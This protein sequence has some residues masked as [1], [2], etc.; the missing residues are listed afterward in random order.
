MWFFDDFRSK[1]KR[2]EAEN[3]LDMG[4]KSQ[5]PEKKLDYFTRYLEIIPNDVNAWTKKGRILEDMGRFDEAK[6]SYERATLLDPSLDIRVHKYSPAEGDYL[7]GESEGKTESSQ[8]Q[9]EEET[10]YSKEV[11]EK[12]RDE[13]TEWGKKGNALVDLGRHEE[14]IKC[15]EEALEL[16]PKKDEAWYNKG[17]ALAT[18]GR[19]EEAIKCYEE[20]LELN[21][22][23]DEAWY[24]KGNAL[25]TLGRKEEAIKCYEEALEIN[26]KD[27]QVWYNKGNALDDLGR[28]EEAIKCYDKA[29][30]INP[31]KD[32]A[33]Y[34]KGNALDDLGR[35]EE[36]IK[37]YDKALE[38]NP[39]DDSAWYGKGYVLDDLG[40][41]E[42][43]IKCYDKALEINPKYDAVWNNK[44]NALY[45]L[46]RKEEAIKC[47]DKAL[48]I[49]PKYDAAWYNKGNALATLGRKE[50]AI[51]C[52]DKALEINPK[53]D[54]AWYN[55]GN[56]L[57]DLGRKEEAIKCYDKAL[58]INPK[59]DE[60]WNNKGN[61]LATLGRKE[62]AIKCY[63]KALEIN[64]KKDEAWYNK[65]NALDDLGRKEE[66]IKCY[67]EALE[68]NPKKDEAWYNKG[69]ALDDLG[70]K[71]E[72]IKCYEEALELNPKKDEAWYNK[73]K[74]LSALGRKEEAI[75]CYEEALEL[76]PKKDEA[77][78]N[79][80][81]ALATL[82]RMEEA[83]KCYDKS[84][85][86][87][88][89][90]DAVWNNKGN[91]LYDLGRKEE[92]IKCYDKA[93]EINPKY[94][95]AW[96]N[97][98]IVLS[99]LG[100]KEE[101]I[102][103]YDKAL[104]INPKDDSAWYG[105]GYVLDD[106]GRKEEAIKCYD[107]SLEINPEK[108]E[109][110]KKKEALLLEINNRI[111]DKAIIVLNDAENAFEKVKDGGF[112]FSDEKLEAAWKCFEAAN[113]VEAMDLANQFKSLLLRQQ[114]KEVSENIKESEELLSKSQSL[115]IS[116]NKE[117]L[118]KA[119]IFYGDENYIE[120]MSSA[121]VFKNQ[122]MNELKQKADK[123]LIDSEEA[124]AEAKASKI[125]IEGNTLTEANKFFN[126]QSYIESIEACNKFNG[127]LTS[128]IDKRR[129]AA[130]KEI[131]EAEGFH[132]KFEALKAE[133]DDSLLKKAKACFN[134]MLYVE[135]IE[136]S[137]SFTVMAEELLPKLKPSMSVE[138]RDKVLK[139]SSGK[140]T[141]LFLKNTGEVSAQNILLNIKGEVEF[142][143]LSEISSVDKGEL[144][145]IEVWIKPKSGGDLL[146]DILLEYKDAIEREYTT[147]Q[148]IWM[149]VTSSPRSSN[150]LPE[151]IISYYSNVSFVGKGGF[152]RVFRATNKKGD[153]VALKIP[154]NLDQSTGKSFLKEIAVWQQ[155][156]HDN[157]INIHDLNILPFPYIEMEFA[158]RGALSEINK[159]MDTEIAAKVIFDIS[160][161]LKHAH[162]NGII[163]R[164]LKPH[165]IL[166]TADMTPKITDWGLSKV[167]K[168]STSSQSA[169]YTP[170][171]A[172]PEQLSPK[173][174][175]TPDI[176]TDIYQL[177][178]VFYELVTG[179]LPFDGDDF[180]E[181]GFAIL[182]ENP[183]IPSSC[184]PSCADLD[185]IIMKCLEKK[186]ADRYQNM[187]EFQADLASYLKLEYSNSLN[188]SAG[189]LKRSC[190]YCGDLLLINAKI[191]DAESA[192]KY[193]LDMKNYASGNYIEDFEDIIK[194]LDYAVARK[195]VLS[196]EL[197]SKLKVIVH[198]VK[199]GR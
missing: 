173:K 72:A 85:E 70:R 147:E 162:E 123:F 175:G 7:L 37:C 117:P 178:V 121:K 133:C 119:R 138:I 179:K 95:A 116:V 12:K 75:K 190:I 105:K 126:E 45:D 136:H 152:A 10:N 151:D 148:A 90:Y 48:E 32:E 6:R 107:K 180:S 183:D 169:G 54:E 15:Y 185:D 13:A 141:H 26:P 192:L 118:D 43:A 57:D 23:K 73:G 24:N 65:G 195:L 39:K 77:W 106:L 153:V 56:A 33:W 193:A 79:K 71:E 92:A 89:K 62:E 74:A 50:E 124:L 142:R 66:A 96:Y 149:E 167:L 135:A 182:S 170:I 59:K 156:K 44:G 94:D 100:R 103:C 30:E 42:E 187:Q 197:M 168:Q 113:Y 5:D 93:L 160:E 110:L 58:E 87:N 114:Q 49:N 132:E 51:K 176:R 108:D 154:L 150:S 99:D 3:W 29:L 122:F 115:N 165:N 143:L 11:Q 101:A 64:P 158:E 98:G 25:A 88:P 145:E 21:P 177:G 38:I 27:D 134:E 188:M 68:L 104:E 61:A 172:S 31:K 1:S 34:N 161:G 97:K 17:N 194:R 174:F 137:K 155:L 128:L 53:K 86:I 35:K 164:D 129:E 81:N 120:A 52:Y 189:D 28:K 91:A 14:A 76:N 40:R 111:K 19:M 171:Y 46:G 157:I 67:E 191:G 47:Y 131:K 22:K 82:G 146:L 112:T 109:A 80:G 184:N 139:T 181:I 20:A 130:E 84:L 2:K 163:H 8:G 186:P 140:K 196:D 16:N 18:L 198:Q 166:L 55:K 63:D 78:Y 144:K 159:P 60:A 83:I 102:K 9:K 69:N 125:E 4:I 41:K 127:R 199:M 36:A